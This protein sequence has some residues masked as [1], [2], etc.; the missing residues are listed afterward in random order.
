[1]IDK[2]TDD[3]ILADKNYTAYDFDCDTSALYNYF[4]LEVTAA[5]SGLVLQMS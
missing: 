1:V 4:K 3:T 2:R 5:K